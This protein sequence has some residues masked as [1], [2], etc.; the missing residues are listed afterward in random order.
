[1]SLNIAVL[2]AKGMLGHMVYNFLKET[3]KYNVYGI[4]R[5][6]FDVFRD[7][8]HRLGYDLV[9]N[10]DEPLMHYDY[11]I[12]CI[13]LINTYAN[14]VDNLYQTIRINT[15]FPHEL[16]LFAQDQNSKVIHISTDCI[17]GGK[18]WNTSLPFGQVQC[19]EHY[20][21]PDATDIYGKTKYLGELNY[22]NCLT[23]RQSIIGPELKNGKGLFHWICSKQSLDNIDGYKDHY[24]NGL[25][26]LELAKNIEQIL[27]GELYKDLWGSILNNV[28]RHYITKYNLLQLVNTIFELNVNIREFSISSPKNMVLASDKPSYGTEPPY[29]RMILELKEWMK[30]HK[31]LY[32]QYERILND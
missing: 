22:P 19:Y 27:I 7:P 4:T 28:P 30:F 8:V 20:M 3:G 24:W 29:K 17:Y 32:S 1:M 11:Y 23:L 6:H 15:L 21:E 31:N 13:G 2:G 25:T 14:N 5:E 26:T 18:L 9:G 10:F 16:A 12:N